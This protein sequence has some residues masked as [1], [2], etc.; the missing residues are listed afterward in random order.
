MTPSSAPSD[1]TAIEPEPPFVRWLKFAV[2]AMG[3]MIVLGVLGVIARIV[4]LASQGPRPPSGVAASARLAP[5][6][7]L[8]IPTGHTV[9]QVSLSGDRLAIHYE[10]PGGGG[11]AIVDLASGQVLSRV[12]LVPEVPR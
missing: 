9:R 11:I 7:S 3:I 2:V 6:S 1:P 8:A 10:G 12:Q 4:Y 5:G